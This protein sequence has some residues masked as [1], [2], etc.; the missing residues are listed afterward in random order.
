MKATRA[1]GIVA[2]V[3][4][5]GAFALSALA[6]DPR[7]AL[8]TS[9]VAASVRAAFSMD[10]AR[11]YRLHIPKMGY[12]PELEED[13]PAYLVAFDG[14]ASVAIVGAAPAVDENGNQVAG[15]DAARGTY[16]GV[17]CVVVGGSPTSMQTSIS[18]A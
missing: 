15:S 3:A 13:S 4:V 18:R 12:S 14:E 11:D 17:V 1:I 9:R 16:S 5:A 6:T 10:K 7:Q 8:C 2:G